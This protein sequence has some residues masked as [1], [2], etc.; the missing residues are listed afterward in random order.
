MITIRR[1]SFNQ[2]TMKAKGNDGTGRDVDLELTWAWAPELSAYNL[3]DRCWLTKTE[4]KFD[5]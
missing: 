2:I 5:S 1:S 4:W 3:T